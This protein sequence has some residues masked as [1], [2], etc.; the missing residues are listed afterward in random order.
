MEQQLKDLKG[1]G[2]GGGETDRGGRTSSRPF[3]LEAGERAQDPGAVP[4]GPRGPRLP[5]AVTQAQVSR[6]CRHSCTY[7]YLD[8]GPESGVKVQEQCQQ[9]PRALTPTGCG[10]NTSTGE[11]GCVVPTSPRFCFFLVCLFFF[12]CCFFCQN[13]ITSKGIFAETSRT[14][15]LG[16]AKS[17]S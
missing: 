17:P 6:D 1:G 2:G 10:P 5:P 14:R 11:W 16:Q 8:W 9:D 15:A 12:F 7:S 4:A 13:K 3:G